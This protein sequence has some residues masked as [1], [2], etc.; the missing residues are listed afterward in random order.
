MFAGAGYA[1]DTET[2]TG[3]IENLD[4]V[5]GGEA[6]VPKPKP[7]FNLITKPNID[8]YGNPSTGMGSQN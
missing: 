2:I 7:N 4:L 6:I 1:V 5:S 8:M 3:S